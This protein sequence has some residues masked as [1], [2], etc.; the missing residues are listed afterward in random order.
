[1]VIATAYLYA[2]NYIL[3]GEDV[4]K[5]WSTATQ[6]SCA[7][8]KAYNKGYYEGL[9]RLKKEEIHKVEPNRITNAEKFEEVFG[10]KIESTW[11][12]CSNGRTDYVITDEMCKKCEDRFNCKRWLDA[13]WEAPRKE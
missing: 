11:D 13:P 4:T 2:T 7:L 10:D 1:M 12:E 9:Q 6:N 3:F 8:E 5:Q